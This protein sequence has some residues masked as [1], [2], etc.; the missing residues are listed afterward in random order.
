M[1]E[2]ITI[3]SIISEEERNNIYKVLFIGVSAYSR[4]LEENKDLI[5]SKA[6]IEIKTRLLNFVIKRQF[7]EDMIS[8]DFPYKVEFKDVN[9]FGNKALMLKNNIVKIHINKT[10]KQG[11]LYN[12][13]NP[14]K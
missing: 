6:F 11:Y 13:N 2:N 7:D 9:H 10:T 14:L 3:Q 8:Y 1:R 12:S 5:S 4:I